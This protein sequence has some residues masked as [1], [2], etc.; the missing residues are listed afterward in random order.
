[1]TISRLAYVGANATDLAAWTNYGAEVLGLETGADSS[2]RLLCLRAHERHH[3]L[4]IHGADNDDI[5]YVGVRAH[6]PRGPGGYG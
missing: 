1:M 6:R 4:S 3:R 5:A 2:D